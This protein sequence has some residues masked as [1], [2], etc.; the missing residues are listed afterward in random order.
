MLAVQDARVYV[1][2]DYGVMHCKDYTPP[3]PP[4]TKP[5]KKGVRVVDLFSGHPHCAVV[6]FF[7]HPPADGEK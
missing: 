6:F 1:L 3:D 7:F 2:T 4:E 5:E